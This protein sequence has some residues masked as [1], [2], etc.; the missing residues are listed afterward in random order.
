MKQSGF[1]KAAWAWLSP[2]LHFYAKR[3]ITGVHYLS[4]VMPLAFGL[5]ICW[6]LYSISLA[7]T[8]SLKGFVQ[9]CGVRV[10]RLRRAAKEIERKV[11][12]SR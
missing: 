11:R 8:K 7:R 2:E 3:D 6:I 4:F 9:D 1:S 10:K 5:G 12:L